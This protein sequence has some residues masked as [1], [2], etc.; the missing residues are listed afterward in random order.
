MRESSGVENGSDAGVDAAGEAA[1]R[2]SGLDDEAGFGSGISISAG[3]NSS[4]DGNGAEL[5]VG[6]FFGAVADD[7]VLYLSNGFEF[8]FAI[9]GG[10]AVENQIGGRT[11]GR[12]SGSGGSSCTA[13]EK[14]RQPSHS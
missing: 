2:C 14:A 6:E 13:E 4:E 10:E 5:D 1:K 7:L 9:G 3:E 8:D 12:H 11:R